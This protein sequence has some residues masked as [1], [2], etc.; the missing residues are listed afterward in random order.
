MLG[1]GSVFLRTYEGFG[2][3]VATARE[4]YEP[5]YRNY[6][7]FVGELLGGEGMWPSFDLKELL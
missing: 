1:R 5:Y 6:W 3:D 4:R 2:H 7:E